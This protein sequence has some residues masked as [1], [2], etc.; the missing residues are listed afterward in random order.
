MQWDGTILYDVMTVERTL[1]VV[2]VRTYWKST[3]RDLLSSSSQDALFDKGTL[4][5]VILH[6]IVRKTSAKVQANHVQTNRK[7][8]PGCRLDRTLPS[9]FSPLALRRVRSANVGN[10]SMPSL[11]FFRPDSLSTLLAMERF[12]YE[13]R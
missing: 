12:S 4:V 7:Q 11:I 2:G 9:T 8:R 3:W 6:C 10:P 13:Y 1:M 5:V